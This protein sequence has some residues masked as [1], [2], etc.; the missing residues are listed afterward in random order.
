MTKGTSR[1]QIKR[2]TKSLDLMRSMSQMPSHR[3]RPS[4][5]NMKPRIGTNR[6]I[7]QAR[8]GRSWQNRTAR[9]MVAGGG[10]NRRCGDTRP[11]HSMQPRLQILGTHEAVLRYNSKGR[12]SITEAVNRAGMSI[13]E[14]IPKA[15]PIANHFGGTEQ[16]TL[17]QD[18]S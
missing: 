13:L 16:Y 11:L 2:T 3:P 18:K 8:N 6:T 1:H 10:G 15:H 14:N 12:A 5:C 9:T 17:T 7:Q 4:P